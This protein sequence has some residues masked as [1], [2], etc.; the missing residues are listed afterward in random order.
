MK[1][2][3]FIQ[4]SSLSLAALLTEGC[5]VSGDFDI[6]FKNDMSVGHLAFESGE[7]PITKNLQTEYLIVGGGIAGMS[8]AYKLRHKD[9][10]LYELSNSLGGSSLGGSHGDTPLCHGAHY[11]LSY[12]SYYGKEALKMLEELGVIRYDAFSDSWKFTDKQYLIPK[13]K[14]SQT[15]AHGAFR[16][17]VLPDDN[18]RATFLEL[19]KRIEH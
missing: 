16:K 4:I 5:E 3:D 14:E 9:F 2:R 1:R 11:D 10:Q 8:A 13:N 12:P 7:F 19:M 6:E 15:F 17:D 18:Q